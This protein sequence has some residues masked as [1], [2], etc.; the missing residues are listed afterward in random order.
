MMEPGWWY[1][2]SDVIYFQECHTCEKRLG[3]DHQDTTQCPKYPEKINKR[4]NSDSKKTQGNNQRVCTG[5]VRDRVLKPRQDRDYTEPGSDDT[6]ME[7]DPEEMQPG[8]EL[9]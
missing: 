7:E 6:D 9:L 2:V 3:K 5:S 8:H 1:T 4:K